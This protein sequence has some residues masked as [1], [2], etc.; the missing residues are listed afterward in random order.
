MEEDMK[1]IK[2]SKKTK[3]LFGLFLFISLGF[4]FVMSIPL[5]FPNPTEESTIEFSDILVSTVYDDQGTPGFIY[6][7][8]YKLA[9]IR[10]RAI[11]R[12]EYSKLK[13]GDIVTFRVEK[14]YLE[15]M[16]TAL[17]T[18]IVTLKTQDAEVVTLKNYNKYNTIM[19]VCA[20]V[21][22]A[23]IGTS[24]LFI[25]IYLWRRN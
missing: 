9:V 18:P 1:G 21:G 10:N 24:F 6:T 19:N 15:D 8:K 23:V 22:G 17:F 7:Q 14:E 12:K 20:F 13:K 3:M 16:G 2:K 11:D 4:Y 25:A 5:G